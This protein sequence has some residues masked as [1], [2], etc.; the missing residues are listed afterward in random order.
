M[1]SSSQAPPPATSGEEKTILFTA[2]QLQA[3][4]VALAPKLSQCMNVY[5]QSLLTGV[6][7]EAL[8]IKDD[9]EALAWSKYCFSTLDFKVDFKAP[10]AAIIDTS[11]KVGEQAKNILTHTYLPKTVKSIDP[12]AV[13]AIYPPTKNN[14]TPT[15]ETEEVLRCK[16]FVVKAVRTN[17]RPNAIDAPIDVTKAVNTPTSYA[18]S[19]FT[20]IA[21][22]PKKEAAEK[23]KKEQE[24]I[25]NNASPAD[26]LIVTT[27]TAMEK[28][29]TALSAQ[30]QPA[31]PTPDATQPVPKRQRRNPQ[32]APA[33]PPPQQPQQPQQPQTPPRRPTSP[34]TAYPLNPSPTKAGKTPFGLFR[35]HGIKKFFF[36]EGEQTFEFN[37][38]AATK[39][40]LR[41]VASRKSPSTTIRGPPNAAQLASFQ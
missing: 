30:K 33:T 6:F 19:L 31:P 1:A 13:R 9:A 16:T 17:K 39:K 34:P 2:S 11:E 15:E 8:L 4:F 40:Y 21:Q 23:K 22:V 3:S 32:P 10:L 35:A 27:L 5:A 41:S 29:I 28:R 25:L 12:K 7:K 26:R 18:S 20:A 24:V 38:D 36:N 37:W 14:L